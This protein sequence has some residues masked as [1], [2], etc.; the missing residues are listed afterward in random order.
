MSSAPSLPNPD[1]PPRGTSLWQAW[2]IQRSVLGA[3]ILREMQARY[4]RYNIG[5]LWMI[6]EPLLLAS[7]VTMMHYAAEGHTVPSTG[8]AAYP[9]SVLGYCCLIIFRNN[10][11]RAEGALE[12]SA[13]LMHHSRITAF[14]I[15][16]ARMI[17]D[18]RAPS[19]RPC[20]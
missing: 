14:D 3:L 17:C 12:A 11:T 8:M 19:Y 18:R 15:M 20:C 10:F 2:K 5:Y 1:S 7:V 16:L 6:A 4:G 13:T 9:F